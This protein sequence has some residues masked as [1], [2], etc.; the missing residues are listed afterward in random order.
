VYSATQRELI[1][2]TYDEA[3]YRE[4]EEIMS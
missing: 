4:L 3:Y 2:E 1:E